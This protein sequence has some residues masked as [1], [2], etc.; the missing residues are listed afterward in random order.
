MR[1]SRKSC[2]LRIAIRLRGLVRRSCS[3]TSCFKR[4]SS[5]YLKCNDIDKVT[6]TGLEDCYFADKVNGG[7]H[8]QKGVVSVTGEVDRVYKDVG[9]I[10]AVNNV[11][12]GKIKIQKSGFKDVVV[13]YY[14]FVN[15][16]RK[17]THGLK[18]QR[19]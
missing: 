1:R 3:I 4:S 17:G 14:S 6:V 11:G 19:E 15:N 10:V 2:A 7:D 16:N 12:T 13:W 8:K 5:T 9:D 18:R